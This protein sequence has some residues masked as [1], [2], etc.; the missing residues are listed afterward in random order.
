M[1]NKINGLTD[2][3]VFLNYLSVHSPIVTEI[4]NRIE[5]KYD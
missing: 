5:I 3:E 1:K 2:Y 4:E